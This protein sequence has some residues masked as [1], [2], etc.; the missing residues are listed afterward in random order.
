LTR[1]PTQ[2][3]QLLVIDGFVDLEGDGQL[4]VVGRPWL[5]TERMISRANGEVLETHAQ[6]FYGCAC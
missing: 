6:P 4:E 2:V 1:I 3:G 5:G